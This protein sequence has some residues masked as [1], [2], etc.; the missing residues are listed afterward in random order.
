MTLLVLNCRKLKKLVLVKP[1]HD[2]ITMIIY[3][4]FFL[5]HMG[6]VPYLVD[7]DTD[8]DRI[9]NYSTFR[10]NFCA[11]R[12]RKNVDKSTEIMTGDVA[13]KKTLVMIEFL[14]LIRSEFYLKMLV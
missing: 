7:V 4:V 5:R 6:E 8:R 14:T 12:R 13:Q 10:Q 3:R 9:E 1:F 2:C 11:C